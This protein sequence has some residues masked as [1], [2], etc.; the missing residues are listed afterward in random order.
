MPQKPQQRHA[1]TGSSNEKEDTE[2]I[3]WG[4]G[5]DKAGNKYQMTISN[6]PPWSDMN[7][8]RGSCPM[9]QF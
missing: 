4:K 8:T 7:V 9:K 6:L 3:C 2:K 1:H 5:G